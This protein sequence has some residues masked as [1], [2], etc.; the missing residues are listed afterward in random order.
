MTRLARLRWLSREEQRLLAAKVRDLSLSAQIH[1]RYR[2][3]D[4]VH[5]GRT[6]LEA[7]ER[8]VCHFTVANAWRLRFEASGFTPIEE[9]LSPDGRPPLRLASQ[10]R[11]PGESRAV[12]SLRARAPVFRWSVWSVWSVPKL[13]LATG[14][15]RGWS[16]GVDE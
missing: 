1:Q 14:M 12:Q 3:I 13:V 16:P 10:L 6:E 15:I 2:T 8:V 9:V 7:A 11:D 4:E 5:G